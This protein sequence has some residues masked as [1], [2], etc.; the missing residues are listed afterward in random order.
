MKITYSE[1]GNDIV[2]LSN[3]FLKR[4]GVTPFHDTIKEVDDLIAKHDQI[5]VMLFDGMGKALLE[6]HLSAGALLRRNKLKTITSTFP[7][8]TVA[9]TNG[10]LSGRYPIE[11]GWLGWAQYFSEHDAN[12]DVFSGRDNITK[13]PRV[14]PDTIKAKLAYD[15]I[16]ELIKRTN[17]AMH[18][19][20]V[21]PS[22][23]QGG[24]ETVE[25]FFASI[26]KEA[27]VIGPKFVYGYWVQPDLDC[28]DAGVTSEKIGHIIRDINDRMEKLAKRHAS[29]LFIVLA[30]HGLIDVEFVSPYA[31]KRLS[32][33]LV[34]NFSNEPRSANFYVKTG[35]ERRFARIFNKL[36]GRNF[37]LKTRKDI[38]NEEWYGKGAPHP[39][40]DEF[41]GDFVAVATDK[42]S[43]DQIREG[44]MAHEE[45]KA[46]HAGLTEPEMLIDVIALN[47]SVRK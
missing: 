19:T 3:S 10:L 45:M 2:N 40:T 46:H 41:I 42:Y 22:F 21:W 18:V 6:R 23:R 34:R 35:K 30:D 37:I 15:D 4:F 16:I 26:N 20:S 47:K 7:P 11:T 1:P 32:S 5:I 36:Y 17:P 14:D 43:F 28:H 38:L 33:L 13:E 9:S 39:S 29:T 27:S 8:T 44:K 12:I 31:D 25:Q 24:A